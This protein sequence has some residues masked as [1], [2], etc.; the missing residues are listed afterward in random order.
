[1]AGAAGADAGGVVHCSAGPP[2]SGTWCLMNPAGA[3]SARYANTAVWTDQE[4][5]VWGGIDATLTLFTSGARYDPASDSWSTMTLT[6]APSARSGHAAVWA[7]GYFVVWGGGTLGASYFA[8]GGRYV[9][10]EDTW[11]P[12]SPPP[13]GFEARDLMTFASAGDRL[14]VWGG[15][16]GPKGDGARYFPSTDSWQSLNSASAPS[17]RCGA[18]AVW[19]EGAGMVLYGGRG[20]FNSGVVHDDG[21]RLSLTSGWSSLGVSPLG[22]RN[23]HRMSDRG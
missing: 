6:S 21:G 20:V 10:A 17:A 16:G 22:P 5:T 11:Y 14:I 1:M 13:T 9:P 12:M 8:N 3:P 18:P 23:A 15:C 19:L 7:S 2:A 4:M